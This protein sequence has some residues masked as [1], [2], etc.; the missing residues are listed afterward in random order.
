MILDITPD[1][2]PRQHRNIIE[3]NDLPYSIILGRYCPIEHRKNYIKLDVLVNFSGHFLGFK[4]R[5]RAENLGGNKRT[6][7]R[8]TTVG[9][10]NNGSVR[11]Y[12]GMMQAALQ[13]EQKLSY[14]N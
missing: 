10:N 2:D 11:L 7:K 13:I 1:S 8:A 14:M 6:E 5:H 12:L 3:Q 9:E 4:S